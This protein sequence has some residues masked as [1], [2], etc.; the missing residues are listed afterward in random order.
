[1]NSIRVSL[2]ATLAVLLM[3]CSVQKEAD[4]TFGDQNFKTAIAL[5]ELH[6]IRTGTYPES[7]KDLKYV[8]DWDKNALAS[9]QYKKLDNGYELNLVRGWVGKPQLHYPPDFW[10]GLGLVKSNMKVS[11]TP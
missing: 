5:I 8:G 9:V 7:L 1:M 4:Q 11:A 6:K 10:T 3:S 2:L